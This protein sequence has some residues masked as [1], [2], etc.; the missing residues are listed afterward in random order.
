MP[1]ETMQ[2]LEV[3]KFH[4]GMGQAVAER[5]I[6]RK[7]ENG[8]WE[9]WEDVADRVALG[10]SLL[11]QTKEE[12]E[13]EYELLKKHLSKA[14]L[15]MS[16]RHLQHGDKTQP[17]REQ[18]VYTNCATS[19]NSFMLFYL[20]LNGSGVGRC[21]DDD[22]MLV[23][24]DNA[25]TL[26]CVIDEKHP[27]YDYSAHE[28]SRDA[29]H[30]YGSGKDIL[31]HTVSDTREGWAKALEIWEN[32]AFQKIHKDKMLILDFSNI[33]PKGTPIKGM[34]NRPASGP[35]PL[36]NAFNKAATL[37]GAGL[38]KWLQTMYIDHYFAECV[39]V[40][41]ARRA[42][43]MAVKSWRDKTVLD[44]IVVKR[45]IEYH[46]K[47]VNEI[48]SLR[49][50]SM[51]PPQGFLWSSN[52]SITVDKEFW[53][54][55]SLKKD[56]PQFKTALAKHARKVF[57]RATQASY[58]DGTGEP[59]FINQDK[60][61]CN[62]EGVKELIKDNHVI[63]SKKYQ[64]EEET[65]LYTIRLMKRA[66]KKKY[67]MITNPCVADD[68]WVLTDQGPRQVKDLINV[69]FNAIV[70]G[71]PYPSKKGFF[72]TGEKKV[73]KLKTK[74]G[75]SVN[76][77]EDHKILVE[78]HRKRNTSGNIVKKKWIAAK[79]L[80]EG[81]LVI[82]HNHENFNW[83]KSNVISHE[84]IDQGWII[85]EILGDGGHNPEKYPTY[86]RFWGEN[87]NNLAEESI[88][89]IKNDV[90]TV[91][92]VCLNNYTS[93]FLEPKTK[94]IL[95][96]LEQMNSDFCRGFIAGL[97]DS[98]GTVF[99]NK[100]KGR[101]VRISQN[102]LDNLYIVQRILARLGIAS[103][104]YKNRK[105]AGESLLPNGKGESKPYKTKAIHELVIT[106]DN[107]VKFNEIIPI[108]DK[109][110]KQ[111]IQQCI[112]TIA[113]GVYKE[114]FT[115]KFES[116]EFIGTLP[117]YDATVDEVHAFDANGIYVHNC[118]EI[119]LALWGAFCIIGDVV[120]F[121]C[122]TI[123]EAEEAVRV[124]TRALIRVNTM[125]SVYSKEV[126]RTNRI[127]VGLTG[128]HEFAWK[129]FK[130]GFK[131]LIDEE[132]SKE[133]WMALAK[134]KGAIQDE[135]E[136]YS[137]KLGITAPHTDSTVKP[138]GT[139]SKLF[140]LTEGWHLPSMKWY[141]RW[142]QFHNDDPLVEEYKN[143]GY[144]VRDL[145][146][147]KQTTI[148][149]FP[150]VPIIMELDG[151]ENHIVCASDATPEEQYKWLMLGEKYW[152]RGVDENGEC[153]K[154]TGS[155]ISYTLKY[156]PE[157]V[158]YRS[159]RKTLKKY[160][161]QIKCCSIMPQEKISSYEYLPE[162]PITKAEYMNV[163]GKIK[164]QIQEDV[165][166]EHVDCESGACPIDFK[167]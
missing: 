20:L 44:F 154:D 118:S 139:T 134:L 150:T 60:L 37:K 31:W 1:V 59:G 28:S 35:V 130:F 24:W 50:K 51:F 53:K 41:G 108:R 54:L 157:K 106:K 152:I 119:N 32:A 65:E 155:Q 98:D 149:G 13:Q 26:I 92:A 85:G 10:N 120:P 88:G 67:Y 34:Q 110:K 123:D 144:P 142:V 78:T 122:D 127:G 115:S 39:L 56:D 133:F 84:N 48:A 158:D 107:I 147:Y 66:S 131:D 99:Y 143:N 38:A 148:V 57:E 4:N 164:Q 36:M 97:F 42:A 166:K 6:L 15:L 80:K 33:R 146:Q 132:K 116:L 40:G 159:F 101:S 75:Y 140:G 83:T 46:G 112:K 58:A 9:T 135:A 3:K 29:R 23:D 43:R 105:K 94:N 63:G 124:A 103:T 151:I 21:Y 47:S 114:R 90:L 102:N 71:K 82:L 72:K 49:S 138:A 86:V 19:S 30:K 137:K 70:N 129:F 113:R 162:E 96:K 91:G 111:K 156:N 165:D 77:T 55:I 93:E 95:P 128:I 25:P 45:P 22:M 163:L 18:T 2:E 64:I 76:V 167:K 14:N 104:V 145:R 89:I 61:N 121:H 62:D 73:Y 7:K 136:K 16:G 11:C 68:T 126:Q 109:N 161:S 17:N 81:D 87:R 5:T 52:N 153:L 141:L 74:R 125:D 79:N 160:Q 8:E 27:D 12:Q 100:E 117:V 69:P